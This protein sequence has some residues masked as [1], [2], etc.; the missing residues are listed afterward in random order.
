MSVITFWVYD[1]GYWIYGVSFRVK[2]RV[3]QR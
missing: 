1:V 2:D 3:F